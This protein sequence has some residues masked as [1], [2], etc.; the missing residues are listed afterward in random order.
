MS[1]KFRFD[2]IL[3]SEDLCDRQKEMERVLSVMERQGRLVLYSIRRMGKTSLVHVCSQKR[4]AVQPNAFHLYVDLNE[5]SSFEEAAQRFHAHSDLA[6]K[7]QFPIQKVKGLF[8]DL[9]ARLKINLPGGVEL[10]MEK[11]AFH[12]PETYLIQLFQKLAEV[13]E[14]NELVLIIDEFQAIAELKKVQAFLRREFQQLSKAAILLMG[15]NQRLL[16]K[17]F[18][19]KKLPFFSFGEDM[20]LRPIPVED[21]LPYLNERFAASNIIIQK[22]EAQYMLDLMNNVPNYINELGA[23]IVENFSNLEITQ[24]HI[25]SAFESAVESKRGR[26]SSALYGYSSLQKKFIGAVAKIGPVKKY[27]G[28]VMQK[29]AGLPASELARIKKELEDCPLLSLDTENRLFIVDPFLRKFL[30]I[31]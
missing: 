11:I 8:N 24:G 20:E 30:E 13:S 16:Y 2:V 4:R 9:L 31:M 23:W 7:K 27:S 17:I 14:K 1:K 19:D 10:S 5:T 15:S 28:D 21:Y 26:Y 18:N 22:N 12:H 3:D 25:D 6:F 29:E